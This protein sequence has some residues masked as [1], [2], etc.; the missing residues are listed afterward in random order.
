[1]FLNFY[2]SPDNN[3]LSDMILIEFIQYNHSPNIFY[4]SN[5]EA[6]KGIQIL[7]TTTALKGSFFDKRYTLFEILTS[8]ET[9]AAVDE[10]D[11][12]RNKASH[13]LCW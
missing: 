12:K 6:F 3:Q 9:T 1:M 5:L 2:S 7:Y 11:F 4:K 8:F 10:I 13:S